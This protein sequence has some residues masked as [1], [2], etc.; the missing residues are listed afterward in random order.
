M[1]LPV[2][3]ARLIVARCPSAGATVMLSGEEAAH[4][5]ARRLAPG[6]A[7]ILVDGTGV[8]AHGHLVRL[9]ASAGEVWIE[10]VREAGQI[11]VD[12]TLLV[13]ALRL[14]RL[15]WV[16]EKATELS[17]RKLVVVQTR[18]TQGFRAAAAHVARLRRVVREAAKQCESSRWPAVSGPV[19][20]EEALEE[21]ALH[22]LFLD[23]TGGPFPGWLESGAVA[24]LVG[25]EGGW[26]SAET[27]AARERGWHCVGLPAG[28]LR[29]ETAAIAAMVLTRAA[30]ESSPV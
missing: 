18:R 3:R 25:P 7:V 16:A 17:A 30:L 20:L 29:A 15:S 6:D 1:G 4:A 2:S 23:L 8:E 11:R 21:P 22:R 27:T 13:A 12:L 19:P 24:L 26:T 28:K 14:E 9:A 5:R 10:E